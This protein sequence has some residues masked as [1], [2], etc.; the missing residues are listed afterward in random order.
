MIISAPFGRVLFPAAGGKEY[1][2]P[3]SGKY[4]STARARRDD[5]A[6]TDSRP[7]EGFEQEQK[8]AKRKKADIEKKQ[9]AKLHDSVSRAYYQLPP[10][11][12]KVLAAG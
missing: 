5:L 11:K 3:A 10:E 6:R 12:R 4:I 7:Y 2:S 8:E 9:D 1:V